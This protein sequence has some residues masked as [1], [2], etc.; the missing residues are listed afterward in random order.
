MVH[1]GAA[2]TAAPVVHGRALRDAMSAIGRESPSARFTYYEY[3]QG[4]HS[5]A[6]L[7]GARDRIAQAL[8]RV[9]GE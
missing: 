1:H 4:G 7:P 8:A 5:L 6:S 2:D 3:P 9:A